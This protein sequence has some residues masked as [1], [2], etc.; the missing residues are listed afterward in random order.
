VPPTP[1]GLVV[2]T[3][4]ADLLGVGPGDRVSIEVLE[5]R[6][7]H[8][9]LPISGMVDDYMGTSA[10]ADIDT[11]RRIM[12]EAGTLSGAYL[13][14]DALAADDLYRTLKNTPRVAG[15]ARS[16]A[17]IESFER[18][19]AELIGSAQAV[20]LLFANIIAFGVVYNGA[21]ISLAERS[22]ELATLR[23]I[24]FTRAEIS[25]ILLG[26]LALVTLVAVP[27]GL[28][29]GYFL[30]VAIVV[31]MD[32]ELF[33]MPLVL[34]SKTM[35]YSAIVITIATLLSALVVRRKLDRLDLVEVLKTRE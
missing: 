32:T 35:A 24:G 10:F 2:S 7:P 20:A 21:R 15:V 8:V 1:D 23:V 16:D 22:R 30:A 28:V 5:G 17:A 12:D 34:T 6:R 4:L 18:T 14:V 29:I 19:F 27:L 31:N 13:Q 3:S 9:E 11:V 26:E 33:R 25:Y